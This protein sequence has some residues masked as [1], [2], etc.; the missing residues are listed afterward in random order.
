M[1]ADAT[2]LQ[3]YASAGTLLSI[4]WHLHQ[5]KLKGLVELTNETYMATVE[6]STTPAEATMSNDEIDAQIAKLNS[7]KK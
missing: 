7:L 3:Y 1:V 4:Q 2:K 5:M 6:Q